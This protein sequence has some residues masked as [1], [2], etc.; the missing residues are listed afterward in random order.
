MTVTVTTT[1]KGA[2]LAA[3]STFDGS[4]ILPSTN[5]TPSSGSTA[6]SQNSG[7]SRQSSETRSSSPRTVSVTRV[8]NESGATN[9]AA[10]TLIKST[11]QTSVSSVRTMETSKSPT[12]QS[13]S[14]LIRTVAFGGTGR[15]PSSKEQ[16]STIE[17]SAS[18]PLSPLSSFGTEVQTNSVSGSPVSTPE[19]HS[20]TSS[21]VANATNE[22]VTLPQVTTTLL[23]A[24]ETANLAPTQSTS[25]GSPSRTL[26]TTETTTFPQLTSTFSSTTEAEKSSPTPSPSTSNTIGKLDTSETSAFLSAT[27]THGTPSSG[28]T[29]QAQNSRTSRQSSETR[30]SSPRSVS[31]IQVVNESG[32]TNTAAETLIKSS[33]QST[34]QTSVSS[35]RTIETSKSPTTQSSSIL[36]RTGAFGGTGRSPTN[37]ERSSTIESSASSPL[38]PLSS[39][40]TEVQTNSVSGSPLSTPETHS[41]TS[42]AVANATNETVTLPQ[43]TTTLLIATETANLTPTQST[44][45]GRPSQT[46]ATTKTSARNTVETT[47]DTSQT[48]SRPHLSVPSISP[49]GTINSPS[50]PSPSLIRST[51]TIVTTETTSTFDGSTILTST[52]GTPSSGSTAQAQNSRTFRQSAETRSS[53]PRSESVTPVANESVEVPITL[54][55]HNP[56]QGAQPNNFNMTFIIIK[57][58]MNMSL[59][60]PHSILY[61]FTSN[62]IGA[63]LNKLYSQSSLKSTFSSAERSISVL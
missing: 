36:T 3:T 27:S 46:L 55:S 5:G 51:R 2:F 59:Q 14:I 60:D 42:S 50:T 4:T 15:S 29:A 12:T 22:T 1:E 24:T 39:F 17:T 20:P 44:S 19:T 9:T 41:P 30:S 13:S 33:P 21:A 54:Q 57:P 23:I 25:T 6:Q 45:T 7:T 28:S 10:E 31:V 18:T 53:S 11:P 37:T 48:Q 34:P 8:V 47:S 40:G 63:K 56:N 26:A 43:V 16:S 35:A 61:C 62:A 32:A 52:H 38:S 58:S 49:T